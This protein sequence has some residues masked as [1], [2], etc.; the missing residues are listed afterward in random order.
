MTDTVLHIRL[1]LSGD[2]P[3]L[4]EVM[5]RASLSVETGEVLRRLMEEPEHIDID[6]RLLASG[7]VVLAESAGIPIAF[8]SYLVEDGHA[9]LD[10]MFVDPDHWRRGLGRSIFD[11][12]KLELANRGVRSLRVVAGPAAVDF[13]RA[14]GFTIVGERTTPLGSTVPVMQIAIP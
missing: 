10:G 8:A 1:A 11:A 14:L 2:R 3:A 7:Q 13:Y 4:I 5:R 9:E 6:D 12:V